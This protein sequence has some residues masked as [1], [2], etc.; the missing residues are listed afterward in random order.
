MDDADDH[1]GS[2]RA[3]GAA[4]VP[5]GLVMMT[6]TF[7]GIAGMAALFALVGLL[8]LAHRSCDACTGDCSSCPLDEKDESAVRDLPSRPE[9]TL[10]GGMER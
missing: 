8:P 6:G 3:G 7:L 10:S 9:Q 4:P 5:E 1:D 2:R